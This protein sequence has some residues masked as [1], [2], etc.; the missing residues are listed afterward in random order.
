MT[1]SNLQFYDIL[2]NILSFD[3]D[4]CDI[5]VCL[6]SIAKGDSIPIFTRLEL[7]QYLTETFR[8]VVSSTIEEC[9]KKLSKH[10]IDLFN[11]TAESKLDDYEIEAIDLTQYEAISKKIEPL[12]SFQDLGTFQEE[13]YLIS[14]LRFYV[15]IVRPQNIEPIFFY[16]TMTSKMLLSRSPFFAI[17]RGR[18]EYDRIKEPVLLFDR[19]IDCISQ[20]KTMFIIQKTNFETIFSFTE[21]IE[22]LAKQSLERIKKK[23]PIYN[24]DQFEEACKRHPTKLR[25][26]RNIAGQEYLDRITIEDIKKVIE[27]NKLKIQTVVLQNH[28][29]KIIYDDQYPWE[30]LKLLDDD[31]LKS[32][33]TSQNYEVGSKRLR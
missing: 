6:A 17:W 27:T 32:V 5:D 2:N 30:I 23:I 21:E 22:K 28:E 3:L 9:K 19:N 11:Y 18:D 12:Q 10:D 31:F 4:T 13:E 24:F 1:S 26:L 8:N 25:K 33:M 20:G 7:S 29:E 14:N 15:I 16:H